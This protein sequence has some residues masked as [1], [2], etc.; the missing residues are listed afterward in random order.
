MLLGGE[1]KIPPFGEVLFV[2]LLNAD[3]VKLTFVNINAPA[4][5]SALFERK[6]LFARSTAQLGFVL[7]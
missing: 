4:L 5:P 1:E 7:L 2:K 6:I 3:S